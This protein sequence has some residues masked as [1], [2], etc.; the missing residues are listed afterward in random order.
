MLR[1]DA[2]TTSGRERRRWTQVECRAQGRIADGVRGWG[3]CSGAD[4]RQRGAGWRGTR[5][6]VCGAIAVADSQGERTLHCGGGGCEGHPRPG[7]LGAD[8]NERLS[9]ASR[10]EDAADARII[11]CRSRASVRSSYGDGG[12]RRSSAVGDAEPDTP[13][14]A[15]SKDQ[16]HPKQ[17][18]RAPARAGHYALAQGEPSGL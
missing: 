13:S 4:E 7:H 2:T 5:P 6:G 1:N 3:R 18:A 16:L 9:H 11:A 14:L 10:L 15:R 17:G 12:G 8:N